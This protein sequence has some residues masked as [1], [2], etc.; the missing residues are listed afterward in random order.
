MKKFF[1]LAFIILYFASIQPTFAG[2]PIGKK[3]FLLGAGVSAFYAKDYWDR[4]GKYV[5]G[6]KTFESYSL[7]MFGN[8][9]LSR[10]LDFMFSVPIAVQVNNYATAGNR[11]SAG[12][13]DLQLGLSYNVINYKYK[14]YTS[15][16]GGVIVPLYAKFDEQ[17][18][19]LGMYGTEVRLMNTGN[20]AV[21]DKKAYYNLEAGY[22]QYY[23]TNGPSQFTYL[24]AFGYAI[25]KENQL[26]LDVSGTNS[27]S[28]DKS[29][30]IFVGAARDYRY[31][32]SS[33]SYG[34]VF[35]RRVS[36]FASGFY[37][38]TAR[39]TGRGYGGSVQGLFRF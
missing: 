7:G 30:T 11:S 17:T 32:R 34:H 13:G 15:V 1:Y 22:R 18:L 25:D 35:S 10:R 29:T 6:T 14:N 39:N 9:G 36:V 26:V 28:P 12:V 20:L 37:T 33:I 21:E 27:Y 3:R 38:L 5:K 8:Y 19:G 24:A 2:W 4:N 16:Y 23:D 31:T